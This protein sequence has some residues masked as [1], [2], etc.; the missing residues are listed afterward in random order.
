MAAVAWCEMRPH[1]GYVQKLTKEPPGK[2]EIKTWKE[3]L[4]VGEE[5]L[6]RNFILT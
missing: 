5:N 6:M 3:F 1:Q 4:A 2:A